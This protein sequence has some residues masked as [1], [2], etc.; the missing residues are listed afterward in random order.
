MNK[1]II[2]GRLTRDPELKTTPSQ[3]SVSSFSVAVDRR[4]KNS[5]GERQADFIDVV[6]W[7]Q[8]AEFVS[9]YFRKGSRIVVIGSIQTRNWEDQ[10]GKKR[11]ATELVAEEIYFG[12]SKGSDGG[13]SQN[14][15]GGG[16]QAP[17]S[18]YGQASEA[19]GFFPAPDDDTSL[20]FDL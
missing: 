14:T 1:G 7:R 20:P 2:M 8:N 15:Y 18:N 19:A 17:Q 12:D 5:N 10:D 11:K 13:A 3:V 9:K 16:S 4:F 6:A